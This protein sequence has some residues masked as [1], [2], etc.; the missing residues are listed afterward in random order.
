MI[1]HGPPRKSF[2][3]KSGKNAPPLAG[4]P[5]AARYYQRSRTGGQRYSPSRGPTALDT[6]LQGRVSLIPPGETGL[7]VKEKL[8]VAPP[9]FNPPLG[10]TAQSVRPALRCP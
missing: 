9:P 7:F 1:F 8:Y 2:E 5:R 6:A 3:A 10:L 4:R